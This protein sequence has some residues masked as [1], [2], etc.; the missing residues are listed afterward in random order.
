M[1]FPVRVWSLS[2]AMLG[3]VAASPALAQA[4]ASPR[5]Q[6]AAA[7]PTPAQVQASTAEAKRLSDGFG[8]VAERVS[9]S[10]VQI[11]VTARDEKAEAWARLFG[12][13][14]GDEAVARGT[15][16]GVVF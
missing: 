5:A 4:P 10:V 8:A 7:V 9:P 12:K 13:G 2:V 11:D 1:N 15:G 16:S 6:P 3:V 14:G